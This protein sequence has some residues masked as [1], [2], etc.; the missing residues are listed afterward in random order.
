[1]TPHKR[2]DLR[3]FLS[4]LAVALAL[5]LATPHLARAVVIDFDNQSGYTDLTSTAFVKDGY[6][7]TGNVIVTGLATGQA[8]LED[9]PPSH[10]DDRVNL[11]AFPDHAFD[12]FALSLVIERVDAAPFSLVSVDFEGLG[13][14][15]SAGYT[16]TVTP[17]GETPIPITTTGVFPFVGPSVENK[18]SF[19]I[20]HAYDGSGAA[21]TSGVFVD[22]ITLVP[23]PSTVALAAFGL[24]VLAFC[25]RRRANSL[26]NLP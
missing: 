5:P 8:V 19:T 17:L 2:R 14:T 1:M 23:E 11:I 15:G 22:D 6:R 9:V 7:F 20:T 24:V 16:T 18:L 25:R 13:F 21:S 10:P 4:I 3:F 12:T 26:T